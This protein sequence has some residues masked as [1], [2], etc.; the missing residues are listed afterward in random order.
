MAQECLNLTGETVAQ[1]FAEFF[2]LK[3]IGCSALEVLRS[4][5]NMATCTNVD[6]SEF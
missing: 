5:G 1:E 3:L 4:V 2:Q 6:G